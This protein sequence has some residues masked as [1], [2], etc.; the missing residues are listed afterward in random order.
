M[1]VPHISPR[2][3]VL[4]RTNHH[5]IIPNIRHIA[6]IIVGYKR[7]KISECLVNASFSA[8]RQCNVRWLYASSSLFLCT[9]MS[10]V[11]C[12]LCFNLQSYC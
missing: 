8:I 3:I 1:N 2:N 5:P 10:E 4:K 7:Q 9:K 11:S 6:V 12:A